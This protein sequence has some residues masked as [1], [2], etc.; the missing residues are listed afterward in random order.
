MLK[1]TE[2]AIKKENIRVGK[3]VREVA[4]VKKEEKKEASQRTLEVKVQD[5]K[6]GPEPQSVNAPTVGE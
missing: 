4:A 2:G 6:V 3:E 5:T 1:G